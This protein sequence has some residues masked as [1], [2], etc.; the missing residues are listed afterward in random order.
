MPGTRKWTASKTLRA[1]L[2]RRARVYVHDDGVGIPHAEQQ[3]VWERFHRAADVT[4]QSGSSV[5]LGLGLHIS[6]NIVERHHGQV[7]VISAPD[8]GTT[9]WFALPLAKLGDIGPLHAQ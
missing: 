2:R 7:G 4:V 9:F 5:S 3:R 1:M 8:Q 6:K